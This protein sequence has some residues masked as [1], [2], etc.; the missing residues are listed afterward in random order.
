MEQ[1]ALDNGG[2]LFHIPAWLGWAGLAFASVAIPLLAGYFDTKAPAVNVQFEQLFVFQLLGYANLLLI[3]S[4]VLY[5]GHLW[6]TSETVGRWA[7]GLAAAGALASLLALST[8]WL[9]AYYLQQPGHF[10]LNS[11]YETVALFSTITVVIYLVMERV[12]RTRSA[13]A[14]VMLIVFSAVLFQVWLAA[15]DQAIPGSRVRILKSYWMY[16]HVL[17]NF[18]GYGAFAVAAAMGAAYLIRTCDVSATGGFSSFVVLPEPERLDRLMH[19]A[20]L[21]GFPVFTLATILGSV[22]AYQSWGRYW[23]WDPKETWALLV[24]V[25]Y[26]SY[27]L[28]RYVGRW[29]GRRMAWWI[30]AG[31]ALTAF[32][33]LGVNALWPGR[34]AEPVVLHQKWCP[35][36]GEKAPCT[37]ID[38]Y[39]AD[40]S[41]AV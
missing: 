3:A 17:G 18:I 40:V 31:F 4:T 38:G 28:I 15:N 22:W 34:H 16:A 39:H 37:P 41:A 8:R 19:N 10:S 21:L 7:S 25:T 13:G 29:C 35:D 24:W 36:A 27:F 32:C 11:M 30:I 23:A 5:V 12:Y 2:R 9:E 26:A 1:Q 6:F 33:F 20:I 14:F